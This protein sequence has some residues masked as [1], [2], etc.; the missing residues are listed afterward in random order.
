MIKPVPGS[1][2]V[3][4]PL[5]IVPVPKETPLSKKVTVPM[6]DPVIAVTVAL[7]VTA[8]PIGDEF[9]PEVTVVTVL[10]LL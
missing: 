7:K 6:G 8:W 3:A 5:T 10:S 4:T 2:T 1:V 9:L